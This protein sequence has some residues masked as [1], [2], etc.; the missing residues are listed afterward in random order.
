VLLSHPAEGDVGIG[1][2]AGLLDGPFA[3]QQLARSPIE[4]PG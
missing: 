1:L 4:S 2:L 3:S